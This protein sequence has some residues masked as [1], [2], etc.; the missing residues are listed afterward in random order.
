M[1]HASIIDYEDSEDTTVFI[2]I[3]IDGTRVAY[4]FESLNAAIEAL[5]NLIDKYRD[6][7]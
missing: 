3:V 6:I 1:I 5:P 2:H 7:D 4:E